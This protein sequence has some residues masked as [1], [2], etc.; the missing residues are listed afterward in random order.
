[1]DN[2]EK[3]ELSDIL[4]QLQ[5]IDYVAILKMLQPIIIYYITDRTIKGYNLHKKY[6]P[7]NIS[8]VFLPPELTQEYS[9]I[10]ID[11]WTSH[12][13]G[14]AIVEFISVV[15]TNFS[16][17]DLINFRNNLNELK[18]NPKK[19][20]LHNLIFS[21]NTVADYDIKKNLIRVDGDNYVS[22]IYHE[23][24]H[25]ASSTYRDGIRY[26]GFSQSSLKSLYSLGTGIDE[27]YTQL[28]TERYFENIEEVKGA[29]KYEVHIVEKLEQIV[30]REKMQSF[31]L[32]ANL[33]GLINEL[34]Q[35]ATEEEIMKF[36]SGVDFLKEH[37]SDKK[38]L[39]FE[40]NMITNSLK[41]INEFLLKS[42]IIKL[43]S[44]LD[45]GKLNIYELTEKLAIYISSLG[46]SIKAGKHDYEYLNNDYIQE[47][48]RT[49]LDAPELTVSISKDDSVSKR[50]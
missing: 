25:M 47:S 17:M 2:K 20:G 30:G 45:I 36:I 14:N 37:L 42:Y 18:I 49:I 12:R 9:N 11:N 3:L 29:Y 38:L 15:L 6:R 21:S 33:S 19:F 46:T 16:S 4:I 8:K 40:K 22:S 39:P 32:N 13:F 5:Q 35:Y 26:S 7:Q 48:L 23:L 43:K 31:Y 41:N 10:D 28:L 1:M 24:F 27:G 44:E 50:K 34:K